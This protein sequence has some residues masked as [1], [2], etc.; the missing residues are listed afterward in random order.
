MSPHEVGLTCQPS[1]L[2]DT[3]GCTQGG[4]PSYTVDASGVTQFQSWE[5]AWGVQVVAVGTSTARP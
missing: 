4:Y 1:S 2:L 3:G 5:I